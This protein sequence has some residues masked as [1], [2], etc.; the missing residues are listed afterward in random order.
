MNTSKHQVVKARFSFNG[1]ILFTYTKLSFQKNLV[2]FTAPIILIPILIISNTLN[3]YN[4]YRDNAS[5]E[6]ILFFSFLLL[7]F[8]LTI[9]ALLK[10]KDAKMMD[11]KEFAF[12]DIKLVR[13]R[14]S[15]KNAKLAFE[16]TNG[17]KHKM[18]IKKD[19]AYSN[20]FKNISYANVTISANKS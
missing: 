8:L 4:A 10:Y 6:I 3:L 19:D 7:S 11:G 12:R 16:F 1:H 18:T 9:I 13:I 2:S 17:L 15:N 14:E 20:F 5:F